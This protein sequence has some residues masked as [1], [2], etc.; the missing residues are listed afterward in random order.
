MVLA[1]MRRP[2]ATPVG[3]HAEVLL[4]QHHVGGVLGDV[5]GGVHR[6]AD[7]GGVQGQR[8]VDAVAEEADRSPGASRRDD[9]ARLLLGR[10]PGEDGVVLRRVVERGIVERVHLGAGDRA[11]GHQT[12]VGADLFGDLR[13]VS[14]G[15][16]D[17]DA[18]G[19]QLGQRIARRGLG[20]VGEHQEAVQREPALVVGGDGGQVRRRLAGDGHHAAAVGE[21]RV[22]RA[23]RHGRGTVAHLASTCSGAPLTTSRRPPPSSNSAD[24]ARR[25]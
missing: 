16:L 3:Q 20:L 6:D 23:L 4:Q 24:V 22:Q 15:H 19:G 25:A 2:S 5:G 12:Q 14:G 21:Q 11:L 17:L 1:K 10:D 13:I 8:V 7:V 18:Q 9:Q